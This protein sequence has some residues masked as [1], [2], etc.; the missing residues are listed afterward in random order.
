MKKYLLILAAILAGPVCLAQQEGLE[1]SPLGA[2][3]SMIRVLSPKHYVLFPVQESAPDIAVKVIV[4]TELERTVNIKIATDS[5]DYYV[6]FEMDRYAGKNVYFVVRQNTMMRPGQQPVRGTAMPQPK[7]LMT[8]RIQLSDH[9]DI[10]NRE[11]LRPAYHFTPAYGWMNDPNGM[12]YKD[13]EWHLFYQYNPYASV[14]GNMHWGHAVCRDL[15]H[16]EHLPVAIAPDGVGTIFSGSAVVDEKNTAGFGAGAIVAIYTSSGDAQVQ[17]IAYS[18]DNGRTF[19]K[20]AGNPVLTS[21]Q[22]D[23]RDPKVFWHEGTSRWIMILAV[24]R[25]VRF[26]SSQNLKEWTYESSFGSE[27]GNHD[28]VFECPDIMELPVEGSQQ[29]KWLVIVNI[30][31]GGPAGGS[32]TQYFTGDFDGRTFTCESSPETVKWMDWGKDHYATVSFSNAPENRHVVLA[33][34]SNWQYAGAVPTRQFRS[35]NSIPRELALYRFGNE[36]YVKVLPAREMD[37][38]RSAPVRKSVGTVSKARTLSQVLPDRFEME[39]TFKPRTARRFSMEF[40][41]DEGEKVVM[42]YDLDKLQFGMDRNESGAVSFS[43]AF[44]V[45][46]FAPIEKQNQ[47]TL[48]VF[49]DNCSIEAFDGNGRMAMTNLVFPSKPYRNVRIL[50]ETGSVQVSSM[51]IWPQP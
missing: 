16:W 39:V 21:N 43:D 41:N 6:P 27:Y 36:H 8:D 40:S 47:Y 32:A 18:N 7:P 22:G 45:P 19:K 37:G 15:T 50:P 11:P 42:T 51:T 20:Y 24:G 26:F 48:R 46:T 23:F 25:E 9:F 44:P 1:I 49:V 12:V 5:I 17:S 34:M 29:K 14:W 38:L 35:A 4:N 13:G 2:R 3:G 31:P 28:G 33:W 30:N 10:T